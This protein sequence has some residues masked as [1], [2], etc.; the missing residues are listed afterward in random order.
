MRMIRACR[1]PWA[2]RLPEPG[3]LAPAFP[4][5]V[6]PLPVFPLAGFPPAGLLVD[7]LLA[8]SGSLHVRRVTAPDIN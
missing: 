3:T 6:F 7:G 1:R 5:P 8:M 2:S 4:L